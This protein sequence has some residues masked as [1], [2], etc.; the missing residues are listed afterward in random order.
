MILRF[1]LWAL[2]ISLAHVSFASFAISRVYP[3]LGGPV[4][5]YVFSRGVLAAA[6]ATAFYPSYLLANGEISFGGVV[7]VT[8]A[9]FMGL[10]L[11]GVAVSAALRLKRSST[12]EQRLFWTAPARRLI[13]GFRPSASSVGWKTKALGVMGSAIYK[14]VVREVLV[15][16]EGLP[17]R[18][19]GMR[20]LHVS[21]THMGLRCGPE[22]FDALLDELVGLEPDLVFHTGDLISLKSRIEPASEWLGMLARRSRLGAYC[23]LGNHDIGLAP[24]DL[25]EAL[26]KKDCRRLSNRGKQLRHKGISMGIVGSESPWRPADEGRL[27]AQLKG[28]GRAALWLGLSHGPESGAKLARCGVDVVF[29]GHTHGGQI[30]FGRLGP[31]VVTAHTG[32]RYSHGLYRVG[33]G[34]LLVSAG[35]GSYVPPGRLGCPP[36]A[37]LAV[38]CRR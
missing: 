34:L 33:E 21:D 13:P 38:M 15:P 11:C 22:Y 4:S 37:V 24:R 12:S 2:A 5:K 32:N 35:L 17:Q 25:G 9:S 8:Y 6:V 1:V 28:K 14:P 27:V 19:S 3:R 30:R 26:R 16:V 20:I 10:T 7:W 31:P 18:F 36:E 29:C 23:V